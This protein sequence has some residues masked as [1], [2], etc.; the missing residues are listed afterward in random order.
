MT[1]KYYCIEST[2]DLNYYPITVR[3]WINETSLDASQVN[4]F[5]EH[6][7]RDIRD[8]LDYKGTKDK[9]A[10]IEFVTDNIVNLN[11]VQVLDS[12]TDSRGAKY[13]AVVYT[14]DF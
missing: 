11:A 4:E 8:F 5:K 7:V 12:I 10:I 14:V 9:A 6:I 13:G 2:I 1:K 3:L